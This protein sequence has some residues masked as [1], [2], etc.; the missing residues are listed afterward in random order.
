M[1]SNYIPPT[2]RKAARNSEV[3]DALLARTMQPMQITDPWVGLAQLATTAFLKNRSDKRADELEQA[4]GKAAA[5]RSRSLV[6]A[7]GG[8]PVVDALAGQGQGRGPMPLFADQ[9]GQGGPPSNDP[10]V[11]ALASRE[12]NG[13]DPAIQRLLANPATADVGEQMAIQA[14][15]ARAEQAG[16]APT[17]R[18]FKR[19]GMDVTQEFD[20]ATRQ[21]TEIGSSAPDWQ[22][23]DWVRTEM[24]LRQASRPVSTTNVQVS[25]EKKGSEAAYTGTANAWTDLGAAVRSGASR[26]ALYNGYR[27]AL[28]GFSTGATAEMR[29]RAGQWFKEL[30]GA[31]VA[32][33]TEGEVVRA[34]Q[35]NLELAAVPKGQGPITE[36]ERALVAQSITNLGNTVE[37]NLQI[38]DMLEQLDA[39]DRQAL[40][41][42]NESARKNGG[43]PN[44][45]E[46]QEALLQLGP[47]LSQ[48]QV[49]LLQRTT[50]DASAPA[51]AG[52]SGQ[53][54]VPAAPVPT[55]STGPASISTDAEYNALPSGTEFI[56][57]DGVRRRKP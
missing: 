45:L 52:G 37:G 53:G 25:G 42:Y 27:E 49:A 41:I 7:Y 8:D 9:A 35:R 18:T 50:G 4:E 11:G 3:T 40:Q 56:G 33:L 15:K 57:P 30:T 43:V 17:T 13:L 10:V 26:Q 20:P 23:P 22:N 29:L 46:V 39:Y 28:K 48:Q 14:M 1:A 44:P 5:D 32:G 51:G 55:P 19:D 47:P 6:E 12:G 31:D 54:G 2:V 16:K 21:W 24:Q 36:N 38:L 34:I